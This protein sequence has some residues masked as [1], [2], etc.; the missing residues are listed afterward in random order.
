MGSGA[1]LAAVVKPTFAEAALSRT[2]RYADFGWGKVEVDSAIGGV[3]YDAQT[4]WKIGTQSY[5]DVLGKPSDEYR[6]AMVPV[7]NAAF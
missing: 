2:Y 6:I 1:G 3:L 5:I 4:D 7:I